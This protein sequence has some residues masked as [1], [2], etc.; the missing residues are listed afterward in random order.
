M[1]LTM[2]LCFLSAYYGIYVAVLGMAFI[3]SLNWIW[4]ILGYPFMVGAVFGISNGIP[5]LLRMLTLKLYGMNWFSCITHSL[6]GA[7]GVVLIVRFFIANQPKVVIGSETL[8]VLVGMWKLSPLKTIFLLPA[9][10]GIM[11]ALLWS[12]VIAPV[13]IKLSGDLQRGEYGK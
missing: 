11:I 8:F 6:A 5:S 2:L 10:L 7:V 13:V 3:F 9:F 1:P 12:T 4:L